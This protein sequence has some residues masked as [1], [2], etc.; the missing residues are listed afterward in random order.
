M[1]LIFS[2]AFI[3]RAVCLTERLHIKDIEKLLANGAI[4]EQCPDDY[5]L[6][7]ILLNGG[8][9]ANEPLHAVIAINKLEH[10]LIVVTVY[11]PDRHKWTENFSRRKL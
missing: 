1:I 3:Q 10:K 11:K 4:I 9:V 2:T 6:P 7:T 5:P 8:T